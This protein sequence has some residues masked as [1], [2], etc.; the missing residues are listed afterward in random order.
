MFSIG[1]INVTR[2]LRTAIWMIAIGLPSWSLGGATVGLAWDPSPDDTTTGYRVHYGKV[3]GSYSNSLDV[4]LQ[5]TATVQ[6][7]VIGTKYYFTVAAYNAYGLESP[8]SA[9]VSAIP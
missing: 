5:T 6:N 4:N 3:S 1:G 7:L 2:L 9:E 8:P